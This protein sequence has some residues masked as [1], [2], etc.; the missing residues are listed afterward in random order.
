MYS[1]VEIKERAKEQ[2]R[3]NIGILLLIQI[4]FGLLLCASSLVIIGS[5]LIMGPMTLG[6]ALVYLDVSYGVP[7]TVNRMFEGFDQF[8]KAFV[9]NLLIGIFTFLWS[10]LFFIPGIIKEISYSMAF[11]ILA[12]NPGMSAAEALNE[13]KRIMNGHKMDYFILQLSFIGWLLL[14]AITFGL[15]YIYVIPYMTASQMNFYHA[16]KGDRVDAF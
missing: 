8:G 3:G 14:G 12:E 4:I 6:L 2:I 16:I 10:L 5:L 11:Y 7:M 15:A 1:R 9:L 13:S